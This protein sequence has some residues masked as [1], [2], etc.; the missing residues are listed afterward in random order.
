MAKAERAEDPRCGPPY[1]SCEPGGNPV[2]LSRRC[3]T[4]A[5]AGDSE[6]H[7]KRVRM[8]PRLDLSNA[9]GKAEPRPFH[10]RQRG[11]MQS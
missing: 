7:D 4:Y 1:N 3:D 2:Q 9:S 11:A 10:T 6:E 5:I 8:E